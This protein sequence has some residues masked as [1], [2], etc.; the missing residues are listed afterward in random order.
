MP[1]TISHRFPRLYQWL[2]PTSTDRSSLLD[3]YPRSKKRILHLGVLVGKEGFP[4][5]G[6]SGCISERAILYRTSGSFD[7]GETI[8]VGRIMLGR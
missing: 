7:Q 5:H 8:E 6:T 2:S 4:N 1:I 3:M